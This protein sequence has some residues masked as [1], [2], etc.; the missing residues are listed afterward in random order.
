MYDLEHVAITWNYY[1]CAMHI[2]A[3]KY[4]MIT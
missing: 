3:Q 1:M 2:H 4:M